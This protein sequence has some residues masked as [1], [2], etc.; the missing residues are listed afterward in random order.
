V[1]LV[2]MPKTASTS[3]M[4]TLATLAGIPGEQVYL[5]TNPWPAGWAALPYQQRDVRELTADQVEMFAS[6]SHLYKQHIAPTDT[7]LSLLADLRVAVLVRA[8]EE[9]VS[10]YRRVNLITGDRNP[11]FKGLDSEEE[12]QR[13]AQEIGLIEDLQRFRDVW[14]A[15]PNALI[16]TYAEVMDDPSEALRRIQGQLGLPVTPGDI[17]LDK[18]RWSRGSNAEFH[19]PDEG[20]SPRRTVKRGVQRTL[21]KLGLEVHR[22]S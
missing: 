8:P 11:G 18:M 3:V 12:W 13:R 21:A 4:T 15:Q 19:L 7:N 16:V 6:R 1:L 17:E 2:A 10:A 14:S 22:T 5:P 20:G 9:V